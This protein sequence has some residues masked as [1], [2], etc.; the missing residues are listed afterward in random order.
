MT[1]QPETQMQTQT[2]GDT[3]WITICKQQDLT[4]NGGTCAKLGEQ[5]VAIFYCK[6]TDN[7]YAVQNFD[8]FGQ[9]NVLSRGIMGSTDDKVY[10]AS[11][12]YKQRFDLRTGECLESPEHALKTYQVRIAD[13]HIQLNAINIS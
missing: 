9:A 3:Q 12:L 2:Q 6:R 5:Q 4:P 1:I 11:P 8:P 10:V 13:Q 7:V